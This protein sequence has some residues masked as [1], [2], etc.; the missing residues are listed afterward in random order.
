[1]TAKVVQAADCIVAAINGGSFGQP[2]TATRKF[3]TTTDLAKLGSDGTLKATVLCQ[4]MKREL[5]DRTHV[6]KT[7]IVDV[8]VHKVVESDAEFPDLL[9]VCEKIGDAL[10]KRHFA[11]IKADCEQVEDKAI[12]DPES[13]NTS[14]LFASLL[15]ITFKVVS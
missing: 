5:A 3:L 11:A 6:R 15:R 7:P 8:I 12:Y 13:L 1:M 10:F 14:N 4:S 2:I 9:E